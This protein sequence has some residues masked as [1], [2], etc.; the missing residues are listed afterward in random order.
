MNIYY[1]GKGDGGETGILSD[2]RISK[3]SA[4]IEAIGSVDELN[5]AIGVACSRLHDTKLKSG[6]ELVQNDLFIIGANLASLSNPGVKKAA[7]SETAVKRLEAGIEE[8]S[9]ELPE[10]KAFVLPGGS[11]AAAS[12]HLARAMARRAERNIVRSAESNNVGDTVKAYMNRLSSYL[13]VASL[14]AN[15]KSGTAE[16]NPT[17]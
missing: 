10:L 16:R 15:M 1:T 13:F 14:Y 11:E 4:V 6:L 17:Y 7:I 9:E 8:M 5:S 2:R 12:L 3:S